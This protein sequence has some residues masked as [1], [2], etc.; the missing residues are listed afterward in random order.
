MTFAKQNALRIVQIGFGHIGLRRNIVLRKNPNIEIVGVADVKPD[1]LN[2]AQE[3]HE[4]Q[5][6]LGTDYIRLISQTRPDAVVISTPNYLHAPMTLKCLEMNLHV[7]CEKPLSLNADFAQKCVAY[8][9][10]RRLTLKV[11]ANHRFWRSVRE[12]LEHIRQGTVGAVRKIDTHIGYRL[13]DVR[14]DWYREQEHSGG[15]TLIDN[16]P[17]L[18]DVVNRILTLSG[19]DSVQSALGSTSS[20]VLG[21]EVEDQASGLLETRQGRIV[22]LESTWGDGDY[23]MDIAVTGALGTIRLSGFGLLDVETQN[24]QCKM[25]YNDAPPLESWELDVQD[26]VE[27]VVTRRRPLGSGEGGVKVM[28]ILDAI[29][30]SAGTG[31]KVAVS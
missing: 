25:D 28:R 6:T 26:F 21:N 30:Q 17:H 18:L 3:I 16:C 15:G 23:R 19:G 7:L 27:A 2:L 22:K 4:D 24:V 1:R 14:S 10:R 31:N 11:G 9:N 5:I 8:A 12:M 13:P 20:D 29:Y